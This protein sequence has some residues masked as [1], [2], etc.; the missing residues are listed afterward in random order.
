ML[1]Q[2]LQSQ[3]KQIKFTWA[4]MYSA[5]C[6]VHAH[7]DPAELQYKETLT[8]QYNSL[9]ST[10][11]IQLPHMHV[12]NDISAQVIQQQI[13]LHNTTFLL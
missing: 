3:I 8:M 5:R 7:T 9:R 12:H 6:I 10:I 2:H 4:A 11:S 1:H 13:T